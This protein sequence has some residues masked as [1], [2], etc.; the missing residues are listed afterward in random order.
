M[1]T[2]RVYGLGPIKI[3]NS[4]IEILRDVHVCTDENEQKRA[5]NLSS[6]FV[7]I[8]F[9]G[10]NRIRFDTYL[11]ANWNLVSIEKNSQLDL[12][13]S[14]MCYLSDSLCIKHLSTC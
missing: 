13:Y 12:G 3:S 2:I 5:E 4:Y 8:Y 14:P 1:H 11:L 9:F 10:G 7:S 6:I